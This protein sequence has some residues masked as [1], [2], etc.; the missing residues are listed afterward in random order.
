MRTH[1]LAAAI[2][3]ALTIPAAAQQPGGAEDWTPPAK[4]ISPT[5]GLVAQMKPVGDT[6][7]MADGHP[8]LSGFWG[9]GN[10]DAP[11]G[12]FGSRG[13]PFFEP[14]QAAMQRGNNW[15]RPVYKPELWEKVYGTDYGPV[16]GDPTFHC[17]ARGIPRMGEAGHIL[18]TPKEIVLNYGGET[19]FVPVDGRQRNP[20]DSDYEFSNGWPLGHWESDTLVIES[21]GFND[22]TWMQWTGYFHSN[23]MEVSER[24][25]RKGDLLYYNFTVTDKEVLQQPWTSE[26]FVKRLNRSPVSRVAESAPCVE[27]DEKNIADPYFRG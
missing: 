14:D 25:W 24:Y 3:L 6:P 17:A 10:V 20:Q 7:K 8:D 2:A 13:L 12:N 11:Y 26:T 4:R 19:R 21:T 1:V 15:S 5:A 23:R 9:A 27:N 18:A 16:V 22:T